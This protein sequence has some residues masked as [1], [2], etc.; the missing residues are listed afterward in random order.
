[1]LNATAHYPWYNQD[2]HIYAT[3]AWDVGPT[4]HYIQIYDTTTG[5]RVAV[6]GTG[7]MC[8]HTMSGRGWH[9]FIAYVGSFSLTYPPPNVQ[10]T[11]NA[12]YVFWQKVY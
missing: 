6:C 9:D 10:S 11:S 1:M 8:V 4:P 2:S 12:T 3:S 5:E 7:T